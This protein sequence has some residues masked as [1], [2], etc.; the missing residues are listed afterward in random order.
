MAGT[1]TTTTAAASNTTTPTSTVNASLGSA[2]PSHP[3]PVNLL[4]PMPFRYQVAFT[5]LLFAVVLG[6]R[7]AAK[8]W[9]QT[10]DEPS[11]K[12][13][14]VSG[15]VALVT[16]VTV[17]L[18]IDLWGQLWELEHTLQNFGSER[19]AGK[20]LVSGVLLG[21]TYA[22]TSFLGR[23]IQTVTAADETISRHQREIVYRLTQVILYS[24][25]G[26]LILSL[27]VANI[28][29][30]IV[31]AGF[32]GIVAGMAAQQTLGAILAGFVL[33]FS[34]PFEVGDWIVID[35]ENDGNEGIVTDITVFNTRIQTF[36]GE[37]VTIP[38][39]QVGAESITNRTRKGRLRVEVEVGVD[40]DDDPRRAADLALET[41]ED[42]DEVM[43]VPTPQAVLKSFADSAVIIG[44]RFWVDNPSSRRRWRAQTAVIE[45]I[46]STFEAEGIKIP[47]PQRE[48]G[49]RP[50]EGGFR[51]AGSNPEATA[52]RGGDD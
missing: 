38:N 36:A 15:G 3:D 19:V 29:G 35:N 14:L 10:H 17:F 20:L 45:G 23:L 41:V 32:L 51:L 6:V 1:G 47:F 24:F 52:S 2:A 28:G 46:K 25:A 5:L 7:Y 9:H 33:M 42:L 12:D 48:L 11:W 43:D 27:F 4:G 18:L 16:G 21:T 50:E 44:V 26:L 31:G 39:D 13:L 34:R 49:A 22:I 30:L 40:Y 8:R 37:I